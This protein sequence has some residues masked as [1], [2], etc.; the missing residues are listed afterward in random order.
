MRMALVHHRP[1][2]L[3]WMAG[4]PTDGIAEVKN[5][6]DRA[7]RVVQDLGVQRV[8]MAQTLRWFEIPLVGITLGHSVLGGVGAR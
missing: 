1:I 3:L 2:S 7:G 4:R 6:T 8:F 5:S